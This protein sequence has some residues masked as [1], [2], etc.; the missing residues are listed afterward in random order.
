MRKKSRLKNNFCAHY[1]NDDIFVFEKSKF[2]TLI[3]Q[4]L[5]EFK[6]YHP[7]RPLV[8]F[9]SAS[10]FN[11]TISSLYHSGFKDLQNSIFW[12]IGGLWKFYIWQKPGFSAIFWLFLSNMI[13]VKVVRLDICIPNLYKWRYEISTFF[14]KYAHFIYKGFFKYYYPKRK[15]FFSVN[16][17]QNL[18]I[19]RGFRLRG[20]QRNH[21]LFAK[22]YSW[23][24]IK[25]IFM[26]F[27]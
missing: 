1:R 3:R 18:L 23:P 7:D 10:P 6:C 24:W 11:F 5:G 22:T 12:R 8:G 13:V 25:F 9:L 16:L 15:L 19:S 4:Y 21:Y 2:S 27:G 26:I 14:Q 17:W 20:I